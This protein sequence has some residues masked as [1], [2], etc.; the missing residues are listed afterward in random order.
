MIRMYAGESGLR[1]SRNLWVA[2]AL[3]HIRAVE[4]RQAGRVAMRER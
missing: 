1:T 3:S 2:G 4:R